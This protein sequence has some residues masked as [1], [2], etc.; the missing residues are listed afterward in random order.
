GASFRAT[1]HSSGPSVSKTG[2]AVPQRRNEPR[3]LHH[4]PIFIQQG[5][6]GMNTIDPSQNPNVEH[7]IQEFLKALNSSGGKPIETLT[8]IEARQVLVNAQ[9][10]V[11]LDLPACDVEDTTIVQDG[12]EVS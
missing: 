4:R 5:E 12:L 10:S 1:I 7:R 9:A 11:P 8:P 2:S 6:I 3:L